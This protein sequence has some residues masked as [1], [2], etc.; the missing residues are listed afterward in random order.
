MNDKRFYL[1]LL[2]VFMIEINNVTPEKI[3]KLLWNIA[4]IL[5]GIIILWQ[6]PDLILAIKA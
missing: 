5:M 6:L 1:K 2:G 4:A 3:I